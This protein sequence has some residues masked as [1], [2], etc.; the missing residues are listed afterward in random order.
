M[1]LW[2]GIYNILTTSETTESFIIQEKTMAF[3]YVYILYIV[4]D[5]SRA[6]CN[7][8]LAVKTNTIPDT[9]I[10]CIHE[11]N[12]A[13]LNRDAVFLYVNRKTIKKANFLF[14]LL[15]Y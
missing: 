4:D 5:L 1:V 2:E 12:N 13:V 7:I 6:T 9:E 15:N 10:D 11:N 8:T 3:S 14:V